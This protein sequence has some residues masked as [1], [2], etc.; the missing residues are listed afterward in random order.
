MASDPSSEGPSPKHR[1]AL[2]DPAGLSAA[3]S[4]AREFAAWAVADSAHVA[5]GPFPD[6]ATHISNPWWLGYHEK[7]NTETRTRFVKEV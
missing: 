6:A 5:G 7:V 1:L 2:M 4:F 3:A